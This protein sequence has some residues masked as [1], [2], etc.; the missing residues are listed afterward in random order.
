MPD[1]HVTF[2]VSLAKILLNTRDQFAEAIRAAAMARIEANPSSNI[3]AGQAAIPR[4]VLESHVDDALY[5][6]CR[7]GL[8]GLKD[9]VR[10]TVDEI[11]REALDA[12]SKE[13]PS[14]SQ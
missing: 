8:G 11:V 13:A 14:E 1:R 7:D 10:M 3:C 6:I 12:A 4:S 9:N 5:A 2:A